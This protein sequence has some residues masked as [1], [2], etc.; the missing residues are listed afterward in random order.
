MYTNNTGRML[1]LN[2]LSLMMGMGRIT[3]IAAMNE[4]KNISL[5]DLKQTL[6]IIMATRVR[7]EWRVAP[8]KR[9]VAKLL[10]KFDFNPSS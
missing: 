4:E 9:G 6:G 8:V 1:F 3:D 10:D 5:E 7:R 2:H